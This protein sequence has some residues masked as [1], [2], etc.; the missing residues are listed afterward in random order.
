MSRHRHTPFDLMALQ[1][2][3]GVLGLANKFLIRLLAWLLISSATASHAVILWAD[4]GATQ[5]HYTGPGNDILA[6]VVK[7]DETS[8]D[9]LYFKFHVNPMSDQTTEDYFAAFELYEGDAERLGIGNALKAWAYSA[10]VVPDQ[11][12]NSSRSPP[13]IDLR[14]SNPEKL[15]S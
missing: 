8:S 2:S 9:T 11:P 13:Y 14:S 15:G 7:R 10:F 1:E 4:S 6:G 3:S 5:V 12:G